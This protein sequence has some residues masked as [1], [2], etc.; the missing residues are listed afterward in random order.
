MKHLFPLVTLLFITISSYGQLTLEA[1]INP[2]ASSAPAFM[3]ILDNEM[4]ISGYLGAALSEK[5]VFRHNSNT[6]TVISDPYL[7]AYSGANSV[8]HNDTLF[9]IGDEGSVRS[10]WKHKGNITEMVDTLYWI[11]NLVSYNGTLYFSGTTGWVNNPPS[12]IWSYNGS[13]I[14]QITN[15]QAGESL[16]PKIVYDGHLYLRGAPNENNPLPLYKFDGTN[17]EQVSN[18]I[19]GIYDALNNF[20]VYDGKLFFSTSSE[21][22]S[23]DGT[24]IALEAQF[25]Q[26]PWFENEIRWPKVFD[27]KLYFSAGN[28]GTGPELWSYDGS[29]TTQVT[30]LCPGTCYTQIS[31]LEVFQNKLYFAASSNSQPIELWSYDG[32]N[33]VQETEID[34]GSE[35]I[36]G[37][38]MA[39]FD[40]KL[41]LSATVGGNDHELYSFDGSSVSIANVNDAQEIEFF[42]N[43]VS[44]SLNINLPDNSNFQQLIIYNA[45]GMKVNEL[46]LNGTTNLSYNVTDLSSG[47]YTVILQSE[48][49]FTSLKFVKTNE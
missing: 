47:V 16:T 31:G 27:D 3:G 21:W 49:A 6:T 42:P 23:Y 4:Y 9:F 34:T 33:L 32:A 29:D 35:S 26:N 40:D 18:S 30:E 24:D 37:G 28:F 13:G 17:I 22:F 36:G 11:Q 19:T 12:N 38:P 10:L 8:V 43:P 44:S 1:D 45:L 20:I 5:R 41:Y 46:G 14:E 15:F 25:D 7:F 39:V 48:T 2:D